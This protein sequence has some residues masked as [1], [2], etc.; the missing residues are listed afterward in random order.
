VG[1]GLRL[2]AGDLARA[3]GKTPLRPWSSVAARAA[4]PRKGA[5]RA[6]AERKGPLEVQSREQS[7]Y[8]EAASTH[9]KLTHTKS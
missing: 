3:S 6:G 9:W 5:A 4:V 1:R 8:A 2:I 7:R